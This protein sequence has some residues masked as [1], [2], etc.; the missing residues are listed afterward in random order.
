MK[1]SGERIG[2]DDESE[3]TAIALRKPNSILT[4]LVISTDTRELFTFYS[5]VVLFFLLR[6]FILDLLE[7]EPSLL[8]VRL[9]W[10]EVP[11]PKRDKTV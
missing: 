11:N 5:L 1:S 7:V 3:T 9:Y 4:Q 6:I 2:D 10:D 8:K